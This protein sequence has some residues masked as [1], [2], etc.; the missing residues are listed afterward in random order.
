MKASII[1]VT[2]DRAADLK[3]T[4][5]AMRD[6]VV[7]DGM[8]AEIMVVDNG[9][10]DDTREVTLAAEGGT[11][12]VRYLLEARAGK[13]R[14]LNLGISQAIGDVM[15]FTDDDI[16]PPSN[17]LEGMCDPVA[18]KGAKAVAGGVRLAPGLIRPW[19]TKLHRSWLASTEWL[20][21]SAKMCM[22][23][24]N[25]AVAREV[26][27]KVPAFDT[28]LGG[29]GLGFYEDVLFASQVGAAGFTVHDAREVCVEHHFDPSRLSRDTWLTGARRRGIS[30]AY[31]GHHWQH[32]GC[33]FGKLR[34][35][36]ASL[37]LS[38]WRT[39][40]T[41]AMNS[42]GCSAEEVMLEFNKATIEAH[43]KESK[44]PRKYEK[45]GLVKLP[46]I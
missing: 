20:D 9:S 35:L 23:G 3:Q 10:S 25:M 31:F 15:I 5:H 16:R 28:E 38:A 27:D 43:I 17:W 11:L 26:F 44:R 33:R 8:E 30:F 42:D 1:I 24:A 40:N 34:L 14:G 37:K 7:P 2:R 29:G 22:V 12:P 13:S 36:R 41:A 45:H 19:M 32:W 4:L 46:G 18:T 6:L 21:A 39:M